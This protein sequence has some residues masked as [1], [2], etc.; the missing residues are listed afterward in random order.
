MWVGLRLW[1]NFFVVK[2]GGLRE[3]QNFAVFFLFV[4]AVGFLIYAYEKKP[5]IAGQSFRNAANAVQ[6]SDHW[7]ADYFRGMKAK[8]GNKYAMV[9]TANKVAT[10]Y[11]KMVRNKVEFN[12]PELQSYQQI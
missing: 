9:A 8:G 7:L 6:R 2:R 10:I 11:Y 5:N 4:R 1:G 12:P 3:P